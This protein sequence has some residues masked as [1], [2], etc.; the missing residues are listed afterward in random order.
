[1]TTW[2]ESLPQLPLKDGYSEDF[3]D[4]VHRS[5]MEVG[6]AKM[7]QRIS[8]QVRSTVWPLYLETSEMVDTLEELY[9]DTLFGG[10]LP[11][12]HPHPRK[13]GADIEFR[14]VKP[15]HIEPRGMGY[16]TE[17]HLEIMP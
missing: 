10:T 4:T 15:P 3:P 9:N 1:M 12:E 11:F 8:A 6:P 14:F 16:Q 13:G 5:S 7:R 17:L 2:P